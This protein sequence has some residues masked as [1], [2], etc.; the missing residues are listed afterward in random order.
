MNQRPRATACGRPEGYFVVKPQGCESNRSLVQL[1]MK[2]W[3]ESFLKKKNV[4]VSD[5]DIQ[6]A[7]GKKK[8]FHS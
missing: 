2:E 8:Q 6:Y 7:R 5:E 3:N 4:W 1:E